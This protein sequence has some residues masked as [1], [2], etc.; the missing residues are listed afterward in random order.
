MTFQKVIRKLKEWLDRYL[1][2]EIVAIATALGGAHVFSLFNHGAHQ[3]LLSYAAAWSENI[4]YY[5]VILWRD[6]KK[7]RRIH[8]LSPGRAVAVVLRH[9]A[10]EFGVAESIDSL[11]LRPACM[12][13]GFELFSD[14]NAAVLAGKLS[15]DI[16]FYAVA[17]CG[18]ELRQKLYPRKPHKS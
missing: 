9:V 12:Y 14:P 4:G 3:V 15:A 6:Y 13:A 1:L 2:P 10:I 16:G 11:F 5:S 7:E 8:Q 17:V 18:Y